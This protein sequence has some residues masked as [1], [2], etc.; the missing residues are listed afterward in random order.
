M[1]AR[2]DVPLS[3]SL[4]YELSIV[5]FAAAP[6]ALLHPFQPEFSGWY[7]SSIGQ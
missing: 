2:S 3:D 4:V 6:A 7:G 1:I 5:M